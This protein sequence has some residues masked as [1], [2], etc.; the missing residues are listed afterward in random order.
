MEVIQEAVTASPHDICGIAT[1]YA[2]LDLL[3]VS[4]LLAVTLAQSSR[5][6][7]IEKAWHRLAS[8][9]GLAVDRPKI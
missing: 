9:S 7:L 1:A 2:R 8:R 4:L 6:H 5:L 3:P